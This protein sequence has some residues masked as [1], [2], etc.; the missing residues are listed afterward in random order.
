[1]MDCL[2]V[3]D[4][5]RMES[6]YVRTLAEAENDWQIEQHT[7]LLGTFNGKNYFYTR[8]YEKNLIIIEDIKAQEFILPSVIMRP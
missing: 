3:Q 6:A 8:W 1:M 2:P 7:F 5:C 4:L